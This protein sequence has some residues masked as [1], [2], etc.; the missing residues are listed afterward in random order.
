[1]AFSFRNPHESEAFFGRPHGEG[2]VKTVG[3]MLFV[4]RYAASFDLSDSQTIVAGASAA[5]GPNSS[6]TDADTQIYGLDLF[7]KW[8][9]PNQHAGFP[10]VTWQTEG[11]ML[12]FEPGRFP[13]NGD[14][15]PLPRVTITNV[16][17]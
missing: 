12:R 9:S 17:H 2:R 10:F 13:S 5:F 8:K 14:T 15:P 4:P 1:T 3:D 6:G 16:G 7:Y 11:M